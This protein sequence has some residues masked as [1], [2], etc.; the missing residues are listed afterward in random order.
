[1]GA[2]K[3]LRDVL[4]ADLAPL[5]VPV[6]SSWPSAVV[7]PCAFLTPPLSGPYVTGGREFGGSYVMAVDVILLVGHS[8]AAAG[9]E[10]LES[11]VELLLANTVDWTLIS[12]DA[13]SAMT[14]T[15][16]GAEYLGTIAHLSK[17]TRL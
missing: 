2:F 9:Y 12:V 6:Y 11:L 8:P 10:V 3:T 1:V 16:S 5:G 13:P 7:A 15:V 17:P 14:V 4:V